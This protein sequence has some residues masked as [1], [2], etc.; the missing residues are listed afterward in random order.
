MLGLA[1]PI[2]CGAAAALDALM[3]PKVLAALLA[4]RLAL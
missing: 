4:V 3:L 1:C 2:G